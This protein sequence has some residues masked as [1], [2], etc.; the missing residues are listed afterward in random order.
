MT[1]GA[2][3][4]LATARVEVTG[5]SVG[6]S[7]T[8][9]SDIFTFGVERGDLSLCGFPVPEA[10]GLTSVSLAGRSRAFHPDRAVAVGVVAQRIDRETEF[11]QS[12]PAGFRVTP[13]EFE[14][15]G[16]LAQFCT[17]NRTEI[18]KFLVKLIKRKM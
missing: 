14:P 15:A 8:M 7:R 4:D 12:L 10:H 5:N 16:R 6:D 2:G 3:S 17:R 13:I 1:I 18:A 9:N 11:E